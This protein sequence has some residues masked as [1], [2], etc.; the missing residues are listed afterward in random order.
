MAE[1]IAMTCAA[2]NDIS[3]HKN[4][5]RGPRLADAQVRL[6]GIGYSIAAALLRFQNKPALRLMTAISVVVFLATSLLSSGHPNKASLTWTSGFLAISILQFLIVLWE[7]RP[8]ALKGENRTLHDFFFPH[9]T[10]S[11]FHSLLRFAQWRDGEAGTIL[12]IRGSQVTEIIVILEG[13]AEAERD[14]QHVAMFGAG[15]IIGEIGALS[16]HPFSSTIRLTSPSRYL[17][18]NKERLDHF[19]ACHPS[20]RSGFERAFIS[21]LEVAPSFRGCPGTDELRH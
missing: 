5:V 4:T 14:W 6:L 16:S 8:V 2:M 18:W 7:L 12:A 17:V 15:A 13:N 20:I 1:G 21:R 9:L 11:A 19:F 3:E 10:A